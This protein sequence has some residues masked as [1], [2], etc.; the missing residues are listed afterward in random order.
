MQALHLRSK[1]WSIFLL[2]PLNLYNVLLCM[3]IILKD[4]SFASSYNRALCRRPQ[5]K[6]GLTPFRRFRTRDPGTPG[7]DM[8]R[9]SLLFFLPKGGFHLCFE[10]STGLESPACE[11]CLST[12]SPWVNE[13]PSPYLGLFYYKAGIALLFPELLS[14]LNDIAEKSLVRSR[15]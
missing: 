11:F 7:W 14:K 12:V 10:K 13:L 8:S 15:H 9:T 6:P 4:T 1:N 5:G 2:F 3:D